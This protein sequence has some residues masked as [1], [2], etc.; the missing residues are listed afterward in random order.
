ML[1]DY[2]DVMK[3][4]V[5]RILKCSLNSQ[6]FHNMTDYSGGNVEQCHALLLG[7]SNR[8]NFQA[9]INS[10]YFFTLFHKTEN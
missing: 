4:E 9:E 1:K 8:L 2:R 5:L 6:S 7:L 3:Y 10:D